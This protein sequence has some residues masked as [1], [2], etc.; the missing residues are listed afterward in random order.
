M[1]SILNQVHRNGPFIS[2][3][4]AS[5]QCKSGSLSHTRADPK[6]MTFMLLY[7]EKKTS[8]PFSCAESGYLA[9]FVLCGL[10]LNLYR[11]HSPLGLVHTAPLACGAT[12]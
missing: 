3:K 6:C 7:P 10:F 1:S 9:V 2:T 12:S 11:R 8:R 4:H 5:M